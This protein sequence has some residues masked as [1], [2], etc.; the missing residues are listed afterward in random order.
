MPC[1]R[2]S[3]LDRDALQ[4]L[5]LMLSANMPERLGRLYILNEGM[6]FKTLWKVVELSGLLDVSDFGV[7][8]RGVLQGWPSWCCRDGHLDAA[9]MD[10]V[11]RDDRVDLSN[12][13][14]PFPLQARTAAKIK[15]LGGPD[16][17]RP[18]LA[19]EIAPEHLPVAYGGTDTFAFDAE[20]HLAGAEPIFDSLRAGVRVGRTTAPAAAATAGSAAAAGSAPAASAASGGAGSA[21]ST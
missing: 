17:H 13:S 20:T 2:W 11:C 8:V 15:F 12:V 5:L 21:A 6:I 3:N 16:K 18:V 14:L 19:G 4:Y 1:C 9:G 7:G 10:T